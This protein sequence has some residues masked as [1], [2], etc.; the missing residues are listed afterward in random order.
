MMSSELVYNLGFCMVQSLSLFTWVKQR[1][2]LPLSCPLNTSLISVVQC[3]TKTP[4][5]FVA[6]V[7]FPKKLTVF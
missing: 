2:A 6:E 4:Q 7:Y 1:C 3:V 5:S